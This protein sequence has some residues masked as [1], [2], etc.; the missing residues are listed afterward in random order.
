ML[1]FD[2]SMNC[3]A[4]TIEYEDGIDIYYVNGNA[5]VCVDFEY[6]DFRIH[7]IHYSPK[8]MKHDEHQRYTTLTS[9]F[10]PFIPDVTNDVAVFEAYAFG[11]NGRLTAIAENTGIMK[12]A[13]R[14][15]GYKIVTIAPNTVKKHAT[16][17]G[18]ADKIEMGNAFFERFGWHPH[19]QIGV[20][21]G[22]GPASDVIDAFYVFDANKSGLQVE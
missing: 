6:G 1:A 20:N 13:L 15:K 9:L 10:L 8:E 5:K 19:E 3:P 14:A 11:A 7:G 2:Y 16:G 17:S 22:D 18:R 4:M 12:A 21:L